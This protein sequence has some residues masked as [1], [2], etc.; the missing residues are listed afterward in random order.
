MTLRT[1]A[2]SGVLVTPDNR[3]VV[4]KQV[5][6][7]SIPDLFWAVHVTDVE[8]QKNGNYELQYQSSSLQE[9]LILLIQSDHHVYLKKFIPIHEN[10]PAVTIP[11]PT[12]QPKKRRLNAD[13]S[14]RRSRSHSTPTERL[15]KSTLG[16]DWEKQI[17][18]QL[19]NKTTALVQQCYKLP[20]IPLNDDQVEANFLMNSLFWG[21]PERNEGERKLIYKIPLVH[22]EKG[23]P[24][25][26]IVLKQQFAFKVESVSLKYSGEAAVKVLRG[27]PGFLGALYNANCSAIV[28]GLI[29][30]VLAW[31]YLLPSL[32]TQTFLTAISAR[33]PLHVL[34][35]EYLTDSLLINSHLG[36]P[37]CS[38]ISDLVTTT[39]IKPSDASV[40]VKAALAQPQL[41]HFT[42]PTTQQ[43]LAT[44]AATFR[45]RILRPYVEVFFE[46]H[47]EKI[48]V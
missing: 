42:S 21:E 37:T 22:A 9:G 11:S 47:K 33:N 35:R 34:L 8:T 44:Q 1:V 39:G 28:H 2:F 13:T 45:E 32:Y 26:E 18:D 46:Y 36:L 6:V 25:V 23:L 4:D 41:V 16:R 7:F 43:A 5:K 15:A 17:R 24:E 14:R 19:P 31:G 12:F 40:F 29:G 48:R 20:P 3:P 10:S 27:D 30:K 38:A